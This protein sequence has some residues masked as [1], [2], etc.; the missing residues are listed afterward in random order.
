[1]IIGGRYPQVTGTQSVSKTEVRERYD[2]CARSYDLIES[3]PEILG[4]RGIRKALARN[5]RGRTL[6]VATGSGRNYSLLPWDID[7]VATDISS[8]ML[9]IARRRSSRMGLNVDYCVLDAERLPFADDK[10]DTVISTLSTCTF[11]DPAESM[12][13]MARVCKPDG[14]ILLLEHGRSSNRLIGW[15]QDWYADTHARRFGCRW[16]RHPIEISREAGLQ[17]TNIRTHFFDIFV[18]IQATPGEKR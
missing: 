13:E 11:P 16:N 7:L 4:L 12:R 10:F 5:V 1:M 9:D 17:L 2:N 8:G 14:Q 6:E 18:V 15:F 3:V